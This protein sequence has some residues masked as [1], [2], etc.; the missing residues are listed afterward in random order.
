MGVSFAK[1]KATKN[2]QTAQKAEPSP[3]TTIRGAG[4]ITAETS[5]IVD[6]KAGPIESVDGPWVNKPPFPLSL[7]GR[8]KSFAG[9]LV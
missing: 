4:C 1:D 7:T 3:P 6:G 8:K 2:N 5:R 9:A